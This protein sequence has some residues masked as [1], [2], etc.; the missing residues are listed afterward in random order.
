VKSSKSVK[1][2]ALGLDLSTQSLSAVLLDIDLA[3][4]VFECSLDYNKDPRLNIYGIQKKDYIA[5]P[6]IEGEADQP[7]KMFFAAVDALFADMR[8]AGIA[9]QDIV[10]INDSGQQHGH[11]YLNYQAQTI[12]AD[13]NID[14]SAQTDL[15]SNLEGCLAY[16]LCPIW[17]TSNTLE[18]VEFMRKHVGGKKR[19]I[20]LSGSDAPLRFTGSVIRRVAEQ[21]PQVYQ[22]TDVVQLISS[23]LP[24]IL[25]ANAHVPV[26]YG[27][28]AGMSLMDYAKTKWSTP[29]IKAASDGLKGGES[30]FKKKLP[31]I[32]SPD[33]VVGT[34]A[35][36]FVKKYGFSP[37]CK[38]VVG[39]GDNPQS[40][41]LV[42]GDL[43][44][45]GTSFVN[46]T[47]T[48]GPRVDP[49]GL[50]NAMY[51][52]VGR[53]FMFTCRTNGALVWDQVRASYGIAKE[54]YKTAESVLN[55]TPVGDNL[56]FWQPRMESFPPS[57][58]FD[59]VR[60]TGGSDLGKDYAGLIETT[61]SVMYT[62]SKHFARVTSEPLYITGGAAGSKGI[63]R[64]I[65]AI[66]NRPV[67]SIEKGGAAMGAA[68]AGV[69]ALYKEAKQGFDVEKFGANLVKREGEIKPLK[70]DIAVFHSAGGF[71]DKFAV[72]EAKLIEANPVD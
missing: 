39:S 57:G 69:N 49:S 72:K 32:V 28:A 61:L 12:F 17:M 71:L 29:L 66:W 40:K 34:I 56:V 31:P 70:D 19:M 18:Q 63:V 55:E 64:R 47:S 2:L 4:R 1:K 30:G 41:V 33:T 5:P 35:K 9:M 52:G 24:A 59:L 6:R 27:N 68:V 26:D 38:I 13:L 42:A 54:D 3:S 53:P 46:M 48:N 25:T 7:P 11:I 22:K 14:V 37:S 23:L 21:F 67:I 50:A 8:K 62:Y 16:G 65:A 36:Y 20:E 58:S 60:I 45:L 44:S 15:V 51:D 10:V 43:L